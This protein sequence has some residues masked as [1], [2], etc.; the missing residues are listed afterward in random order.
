VDGT[1]SAR[2]K[3]RRAW[4]A[5]GKSV[6]AR[7]NLGDGVVCG[8][9]LD[10]VG[11]VTRRRTLVRSG[12]SWRACC[13]VQSGRGHG[14]RSGHAKQAGVAR[15]ERERAGEKWP[16]DQAKSSRAVVVLSWAGPIHP[17]PT[18]T[19]FPIIQ[20]LSKASSLPLQK[21]DL[22]LA[23]NSPKLAC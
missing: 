1:S 2:S 19:S 10:R 9:G 21:Q 8:C 5:S 20:Y 14:A 4:S 15:P 13:G 3:R 23:K 18:F 7:E 22:P 6:R 16:A 17:F 11:R 12:S